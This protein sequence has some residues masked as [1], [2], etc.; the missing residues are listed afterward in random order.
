MPT[1]VGWE[2]TKPNRS[3]MDHRSRLRSYCFCA[4]GFVCR[5][6]VARSNKCI[7][8]ASVSF[9]S[10]VVCHTFFV[11][12]FVRDFGSDGVRMRKSNMMAPLC[13]VAF[14]RCLCKCF[15]FSRHPYGDRS[16]HTQTPHIHTAVRD[17]TD[18][19]GRCACRRSFHMLADTVSELVC[20]PTLNQLRLAAPNCHHNFQFSEQTRPAFDRSVSIRHQV[21]G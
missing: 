21:Q 10:C 20:V 11:R 4:I 2:E 3:K 16:R 17:F 14:L 5:L 19:P 15:T 7:N 1:N 18:L 9:V 6:C 8:C 12:L 13:L